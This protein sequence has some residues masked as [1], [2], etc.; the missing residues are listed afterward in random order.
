M[1]EKRAPRHLGAA[2]K[3]LWHAIND[4]YSVDA[5]DAVLV[6]EACQVADV[7]AALAASVPAGPVDES[8]KVRP[9]VIELRQQRIL[10]GRLLAQLRMPL[11]AGDSATDPTPRRQRRGPRGPYGLRSA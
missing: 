11:G 1:E 2:G 3:R 7:C 8:G 10:L 6:E 9:A 5:H 4:D